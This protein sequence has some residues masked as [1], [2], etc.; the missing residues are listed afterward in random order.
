MK[1]A[2]TWEDMRAELPLDVQDRLNEKQARRRIGEAMAEMRKRAEVTQSDLADLL[3]LP[4]SNISRT[5]RGGDMLLS[6]IGRYMQALGGSAEL[7]LKSADGKE[8]HVT[9]APDETAKAG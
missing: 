7:V 1:G 2:V 8:I 5:E 6:S 4:Q 3:E 9:I